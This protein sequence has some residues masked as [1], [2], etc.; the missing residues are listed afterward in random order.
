MASRYEHG[1]FNG[2]SDPGKR[3][4]KPKPHVP[5]KAATR[6]DIAAAMDRICRDIMERDRKMPRE[7]GR[8]L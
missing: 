3:P 5:P 8:G 4:A 6:D 2:R 1:S 7:R